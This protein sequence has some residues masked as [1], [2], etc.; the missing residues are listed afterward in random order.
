VPDEP[1]DGDIFAP[2]TSPHPE[3]DPATVAVEVAGIRS[4]VPRGRSGD[5]LLSAELTREMVRLIGEGQTLDNAARMCGLRRTT[6]SKWLR[7]GQLDV[8][9]DKDTAEGR[10]A[11]AVDEALSIQEA[12][13]VR[14]TMRGTRTDA[15]L[16]L[17]VLGRRRPADWAPATAEREDYRSS[18]ARMSEGELR[19]EVHRLLGEGTPKPD[20]GG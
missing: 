18:Y 4:R 11:W 3:L 19:A 15:K 17:E 16:A 2:L 6:L 7:Q 20:D 10:L 1:D 13:L 5:A 14:S 8:E 12:V 9:D